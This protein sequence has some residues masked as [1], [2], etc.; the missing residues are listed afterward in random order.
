MGGGLDDRGVSN[1]PDLPRCISCAD[2]SPDP[3]ALDGRGAGSL[4]DDDRRAVR[5]DVGFAVV[6]RKEEGPASRPWPHLQ[7]L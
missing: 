3:G 6:Q 2:E 4:P 5:H 1:G 7:L